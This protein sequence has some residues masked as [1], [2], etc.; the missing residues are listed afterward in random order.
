[1]ASIAHDD[2]SRLFEETQHKTWPGF[3]RV[4]QEHK[5]GTRT[6]IDDRTI[7]LML[8]L[9]QQ[10]ESINGT[11]PVSEEQFQRLV[12]DELQKVAPMR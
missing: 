1:M 5:E 11:F 7:D 2:V 4:L 10:Q 8:A 6:G 12:N 9:T 3:R